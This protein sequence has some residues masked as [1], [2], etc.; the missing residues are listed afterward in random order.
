MKS[1]RDQIPLGPP[2]DN[3]VPGPVSNGRGHS[4]NALPDMVHQPQSK[5]HSTRGHSTHT[6]LSKGHST[7]QLLGQDHSTLGHLTS[8]LL[9]NGQEPPSTG[10]STRGHSTRMRHSR[11]H[12][13]HQLLGQVHSPWVTRP[14]RCQAKSEICRAR[15]TRLRVTQLTP[16]S[17]RITRSTS[18]CDRV[19]RPWVIRPARCQSRD[20]QIERVNSSAG[21]GSS[22]RR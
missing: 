16:V 6:R 22:G 4:T 19:T 12:S 14:A 15:V 21:N 9:G 2:P 13:T 17:A 18:C 3:Q 5:G 8:P 7:H 11:G 1:P 20:L 10:Q